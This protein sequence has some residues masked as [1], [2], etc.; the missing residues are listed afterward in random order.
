M[1]NNPLSRH[2]Q[3]LSLESVE[4]VGL[5]GGVVDIRRG[6]LPSRL[7]VEDAQWM[8]GKT[9]LSRVGI[10]QRPPRPSSMGLGLK[11]P[12]EERSE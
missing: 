8:Q 5:G 9:E 3:P 1:E 2:N 6:F 7:R 11:K 10:S 12:E 4:G